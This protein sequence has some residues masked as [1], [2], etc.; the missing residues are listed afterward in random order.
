MPADGAVHDNG[1]RLRQYRARRTMVLLSAACAAL[2]TVP[3]GVE[4]LAH[5]WGAFVERPAGVGATASD[6]APVAAGHRSTASRAAPAEPAPSSAPTST[7]PT[8]A[9]PTSAPPL[10]A[11]PLSATPPAAAPPAVAPSTDSGPHDPA[12]PAQAGPEDG[13]TVAA[14]GVIGPGMTDGPR[15]PPPPRQVTRPV[16]RSSPVR[17]VGTGAISCLEDQAAGTGATCGNSSRNAP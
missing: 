17:R 9:P 7:A 12:A 13:G 5:G 4:L 2:A 11:P 10:S 16:H 1:R 14:G 6:G 3:A 15:M 8:S